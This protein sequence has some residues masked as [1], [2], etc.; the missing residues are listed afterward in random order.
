M[1]H[2]YSMVNVEH[3]IPLKA[4]LVQKTRVFLNGQKQKT[5]SKKVMKYAVIV[6]AM[7]LNCQLSQNQ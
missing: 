4:Y 1:Q 2:L 6:F 7:L 3:L 5:Q